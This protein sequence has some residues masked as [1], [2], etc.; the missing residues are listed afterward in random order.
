MIPD[1]MTFVL[2]LI[3]GD[4]MLDDIKDPTEGFLQ[5]SWLVCPL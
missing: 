3:D 4:N 1:T 2:A 5:N